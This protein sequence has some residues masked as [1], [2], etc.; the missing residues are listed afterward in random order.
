MAKNSEESTF[1]RRLYILQLLKREQD[2]KLD[3]KQIQ[4]QVNDYFQIPVNDKTIVRDLNVFERLYDIGKEK[5]GTKNY[6]WWKRAEGIEKPGMGKNTA[7]AFRLLQDNFSNYLPRTALKNLQ[8]KFSQAKNMVVKQEQENEWLKKIKVVPHV[9]ERYPDIISSEI[10]NVIYQAVYEGKTLQCTYTSFGKGETK[11][12]HLHP[13]GIVFRGARLE[14]IAW[15][16][17]DYE[18]YD[19][20]QLSVDI[21]VKRFIFNRL[22]N[23]SIDSVFPLFIP[24]SFNLD[25]FIFTNFG[26]PQSRENLALKLAISRFKKADVVENRIAKNQIIQELSDGSIILSADMRDTTELRQWILSMGKYLEVIEPLAFRH[27][28]QSMIHEMFEKYKN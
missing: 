27:E 15:D 23:V 13:L 25:D 2:G 6:W 4:R 16:K 12:R 3:R 18:G 19:I 28:I 24:P 7:L 9:L 22:S 11:K 14:L 21:V 5:I 10:E 26:F 8:T 1:E 17:L 20:R